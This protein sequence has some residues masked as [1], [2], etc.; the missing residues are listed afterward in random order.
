[1]ICNVD[2][3]P[4]G[5][6][7]VK[8][9]NASL[10][11]EASLVL[12]NQVDALDIYGVSLTEKFKSTQLEPTLQNV[13]NFLES[14]NILDATYFTQR[15]LQ[16]IYDT[17][18]NNF[19]EST[20]KDG[21]FVL[22][23]QSLLEF[24][25]PQE[26]DEL[27]QDPSLQ[28]TV[29]K[30]WYKMQNAFESLNDYDIP[31]PVIR[32]TESDEK[33][34]LGKY[35]NTNRDEIYSRVGYISA[36]I[37]SLNDLE[38]AIDNSDDPLTEYIVAGEELINEFGNKQALQQY[39]SNPLSTELEK[40]SY[41]NTQ[42]R[43]LNTFDPTQNTDSLQDDITFLLTIDSDVLSNNTEPTQDILYRVEEK[44]TEI[45]IDMVGLAESS[46]SIEETK[47]LLISYSQFLTN[48]SLVQDFSQEYNN[49]FDIQQ[50]TNRPQIVE[51]QGDNLMI[52]DT[53]RSEIDLFSNYSVIK[54]KNNIYK[55]VYKDNNINNTYENLYKRVLQDPE[56]FDV[57]IFYPYGFDSEGNFS[58]EKLSNK[59]YKQQIKQ[60]LQT[61]VQNETKYLQTTEN[62]PP[63]ILEELV[64]HKRVNKTE[65]PNINKTEYYNNLYNTDT[66]DFQDK[67]LS[68]INKYLIQQ[69]IKGNNIPVTF[70]QRGLELEY[71]GV[72][73]AVQLMYSLPKSLQQDLIKYAQITNNLPSILQI[74][75]VQYVSD[76]ESDSDFN[77]NFYTN[78][79][80]QLPLYES[81]Y[82]IVDENTI[83]TNSNEEFIKIR[84][85]IY[86]NTDGNV[87]VRISGQNEFRW[88]RGKVRA[89][90]P[91]TQTS[92]NQPQDKKIKR[93]DNT[94]ENI[95]K[96]RLAE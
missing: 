7:E 59:K 15:E 94:T 54:Q 17:D 73:S 6:I 96:C 71:D 12:G 63:E 89:S 62:Y 34:S 16:D 60:I 84:N 36:G 68:K 4:Q 47:A 24:Y 20:T 58:V 78:F 35:R 37:Q 23:R 2:I 69:K 42:S 27:L 65:Q 14:S 32:V 30:M 79:K 88:D 93:T 33:N 50:V 5:D 74:A 81:D 19:L 22:N 66:E 52:I 87:Y 26:A 29:H 39:I 10:F 95:D 70:T 46:K 21:E 53:T 76:V 61:T 82:N 80:D 90:Q 13:N 51:I 3:N 57:N 92:L 40:K 64:I 83:H 86:E 75:N 91:S 77:R 41:N 72:Y 56:I 11:Y 45:G 8:G 9:E 38:Q 85:E 28:K 55:K 43:I 48:P 1:M 18:Y 25:T 44:S 49:F 67:F 31:P